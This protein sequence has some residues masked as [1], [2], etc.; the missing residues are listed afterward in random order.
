MTETEVL[1]L[2]VKSV[3][4]VLAVWILMHLLCD[5]YLRALER[6]GLIRRRDASEGDIPVEDEQAGEDRPS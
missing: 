2:M 5:E 4:V 1:L 3:P 6:Y